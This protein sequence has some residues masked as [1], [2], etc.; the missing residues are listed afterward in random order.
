MV[1][2][3]PVS[4]IGALGFG[5]RLEQLYER[6]LR[7]SGRELPWVAAAV[8]RTPEELLREVAPLVEDGIVRIDDGG[9][10]HVEKPTE[11]LA[12]MAGEQRDAVGVATA[13][14]A[15]LARA[16]PYVTA[17]GA[18]PAEGEVDDVRPLDGELSSGGQPAA[19]I[20]ALIAQSK[21]D[22]AWLRPDQW[23]IP[24]EGDMLGIIRD[25]V[26][27]GRRSRAIYPLRVMTDAPDVVRN[28]AAAGEEIRLLP[29]LPT[30]MFIIGV[31]HAVLPEPIGFVDEPRMLVRQ[32]G[33][34]ESL[35][36]WF[37]ELWSRAA[38]P[39]FEEP[40]Q[41]VDL[42]RF[43]LEQLAAGAHDEQIARKLGISLR[44]VRRRVA[45]LMTELGADSRFQAGVEAARRGWL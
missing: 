19:L 41:Q 36:L 17:A 23:R 9:R 1:R 22:L 34:V 21:G 39:S 42:R 3:E 29:E 35:S 32:Q 25:L 44:T 8:L 33:L 40:R 14:L 38:A 37:E 2:P 4:V 31:T 13:R 18:R 27:S 7:Q 5:P 6:I 24:R 15:A 26:A 30:R 20:G 11:T 12:R 16:L 28:R 43:L 45:G 10:V